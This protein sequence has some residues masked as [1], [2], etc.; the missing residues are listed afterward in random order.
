ME[1]PWHTVPENGWCGGA[2]RRVT[3]SRGQRSTFCLLYN[4][5]RIVESANSEYDWLRLNNMSI[6]IKMV[7]TAMYLRAHCHIFCSSSQFK[8]W[9]EQLEREIGDVVDP[10]SEEYVLMLDY[11]RT[12]NSAML[13]VQAK[14]FH[15]MRTPGIYHNDWR[16]KRLCHMSVSG[17]TMSFQRKGLLGTEMLQ[18]VEYNTWWGVPNDHP[19]FKIVNSNISLYH[20]M[21]LYVTMSI[22]ILIVVESGW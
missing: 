16:L 22:S 15:Y 2:V 7:S 18:F 11:P 10:T 14:D 1:D 6:F 8:T 5:V 21:N 19:G 17:C 20:S 13:K 9:Y 4:T 12:Q 3:W